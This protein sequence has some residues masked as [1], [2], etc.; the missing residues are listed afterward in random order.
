MFRGWP[1]A[2]NCIKTDINTDLAVLPIYLYG[3]NLLLMIVGH[4]YTSRLWCSG[5]CEPCFL[6]V[7]FIP[8]T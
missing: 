5:P 3:C 8:V 1:G 6:T 7:V 2:I 4:T